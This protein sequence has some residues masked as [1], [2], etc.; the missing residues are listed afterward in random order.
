M[1]LLGQLPQHLQDSLQEL[2]LITSLE[3]G[4]HPS[5]LTF[6]KSA[7]DMIFMYENLQYENFLFISQLV[8]LE[9]FVIFIYF[10]QTGRK[11]RLKNMFLQICIKYNKT[12]QIKE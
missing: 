6:P 8:T 1:L 3:D 2:H 9:Q 7:R 5:L 4:E 11:K 12:I 10:L